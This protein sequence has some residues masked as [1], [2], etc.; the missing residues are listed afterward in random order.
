MILSVSRRT[1]IPNYYSE[2]FF[3]RIK[4]GYLYVKNP[5]NVHQVSRVALSPEVVDCIVFWTKNP[6]P[7]LARLDE[8]SEYAYY[9]QYTLTGYGQDMEPGL[10]DKDSELIP[11]FRELSKRIGSSRVIW[12]YDPVAV[13]NTYT[14]EFHREKFERIAEK[15]CGYTERCV[16]SFVDFYE[17]NRMRMHSMQI[18]SLTIEEMNRL[19]LD[20]AGIGRRYGIEVTSCC[21]N[22]NIEETGV[23]KGSCMDKALI[24]KIIGSSL[25]ETKAGKYRQG[26]GCMES[27]DVGSY[28]TC[29]SGCIYCYANNSKSRVEFHKNQ[30]DPDA[31]ML[32]GEISEGDTI[33][34]KKVKSLRDDQIKFVF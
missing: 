33:H 4:E 25:I 12:R 1:D 16:I 13:N 31:P 20:F 19:A 11:A 22:I 18:Q 6:K 2:W 26:C 24:E 14:L 28:D 23:K 32:C 9:F 3:N 27:I 29:Q 17:K 8:L 21:E 5:M 34:E 7:M 15:L 10:P 30:Y